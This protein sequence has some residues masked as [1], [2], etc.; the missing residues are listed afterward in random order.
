MSRKFPTVD[1]TKLIK[2]FRAN[3][4]DKNRQSGSHVVL[5]RDGISRSFVIPHPKKNLEIHIVKNNLK[6]AGISDNDFI[7]AMQS[8]KKQK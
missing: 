7:R 3:G 1:S 4:F 6:A 5:T 2:F 8:P